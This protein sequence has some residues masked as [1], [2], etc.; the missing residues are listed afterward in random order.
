M[1]VKII[2]S[3]K[4]KFLPE[5][6]LVIFLRVGEKLSNFAPIDFV[7]SKIHKF[8]FHF[9]SPSFFFCLWFSINPKLMRCAY[10]A[11][12]FFHGNSPLHH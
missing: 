8:V 12:Y 10:I 2:S 6:T 7:R 4:T 9:R 1:R 11:R 3:W 5:R